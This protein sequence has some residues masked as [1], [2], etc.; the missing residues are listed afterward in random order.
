MLL[1]VT[2]NIQI[3]QYGHNLL[4]EFFAHLT[5]ISTKALLRE[6]MVY[7]T[8]QR[9]YSNYLLNESLYFLYN[10]IEPKVENFLPLCTRADL[11]DV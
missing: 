4:K 5:G 7:M 3:Q 11:S 10:N 9:L 1:T 8:N 2:K 6:L